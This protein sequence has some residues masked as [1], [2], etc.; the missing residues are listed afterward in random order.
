MLSG[1]IIR[2]RRG[3]AAIAEQRALNRQQVDHHQY[4]RFRSS[5]A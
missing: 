2:G 1:Y 4:H 5:V 3:A